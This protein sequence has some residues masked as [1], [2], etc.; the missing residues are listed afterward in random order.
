[1]SSGFTQRTQRSERFPD[2]A[3]DMIAKPYR[4]SELA[5][6]V[7]KALDEGGTSR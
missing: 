6:R 3:K 7:R 1:M 2:L 4:E 5:R